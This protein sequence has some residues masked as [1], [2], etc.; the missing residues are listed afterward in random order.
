MRKNTEHNR[1]HDGQ[2]DRFLPWYMGFLA[3]E[4]EAKHDGGESARAEP[5]HKEH[6]G[7]T[8]VGSN[9]GDRYRDHSY[10][11]QAKD[12]IQCVGGVEVPEVQRHKQTK[13]EE[14]KVIEEL[15]PALGEFNAEYIDVLKAY[16]CGDACDIGSNKH[17]AANRFA[18]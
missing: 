2:L 1:N 12:G 6:S 10:R 8:H 5:S 4:N 14:D 7:R 13:E 18:G 9:H 16:L 17:A 11:R 3:Q 15:S